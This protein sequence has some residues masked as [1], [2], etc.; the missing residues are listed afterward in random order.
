[1][2]NSMKYWLNNLIC[3]IQ[4]WLNDLIYKIQYTC[5]PRQKWLYKKFPKSFCDLDRIFEI[6]IIEGIKFFVEQDGGL[7]YFEESQKN[8]QYPIWQKEFDA[9]LKTKY[10]QC[11]K[12]LPQLERELDLAWEK[13]PFVD[14]DNLLKTCSREA[15]QS[16][17][18]ETNRL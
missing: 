15:Y 10:D 7:D 13:V 12:T 16:K 17:Y 3:K 11:A 9:E 1:M 6:T 2:L 8:P 5:H 18:S 4:Y 14:L